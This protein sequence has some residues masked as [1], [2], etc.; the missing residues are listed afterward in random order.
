MWMLNMAN[1]LPL[2]W[3]QVE[4][5]SLAMKQNKTHLSSSACSILS[6]AKM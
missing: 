6:K 3:Q 4:A 1:T 2:D 5:T